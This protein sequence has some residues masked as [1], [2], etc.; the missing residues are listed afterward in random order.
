M[1]RSTR[2]RGDREKVTVSQHPCEVENSN[3]HNAYHRIAKYAVELP[4]IGF[5]SPK[6]E[7]V[8]LYYK[9]KDEKDV[10]AKR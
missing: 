8:E 9:N 3:I 10:N 6:G 5:R 1:F 2:L 4:S 7:L